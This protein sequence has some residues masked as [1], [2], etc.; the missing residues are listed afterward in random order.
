MKSSDN[1]EKS[2]KEKGTRFEDFQK[3]Q[4]NREIYPEQNNNDGSTVV[5][6][7]RTSDS[8]EMNL[9]EVEIH[10]SISGFRE[11]EEVYEGIS[12]DDKYDAHDP[13]AIGGFEGATEDVESDSLE[14]ERDIRYG[15]DDDGFHSERND[16]DAN[17]QN[18]KGGNR[19]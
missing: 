14:T 2:E 11:A 4:N 7:T 5:S 1:T 15:R 9:N 6:N 12:N 18:I 3:E 13:D 19:E 17:H 10:N 8:E 16:Q